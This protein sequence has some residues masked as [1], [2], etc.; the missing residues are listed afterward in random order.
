MMSSAY[1]NRRRSW[2]EIFG[3]YSRCEAS[4]RR[5][6]VAG[7][8]GRQDFGEEGFEEAAAGCFGGG[9]ARL[10]L[11]AQGHQRIDFF[12]DAVLF[13]E[14]REGDGTSPQLGHVDRSEV[15]GL[16]RRILKK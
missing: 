11:V 8:S 5:L 2:P 7:F 3:F 14:G 16:L 10:Q 13:R 12:H 4:L 9:E 1:P 15:R 6:H